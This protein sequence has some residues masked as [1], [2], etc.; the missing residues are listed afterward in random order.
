MQTSTRGDPC[1]PGGLSPQVLVARL[2]RV[3]HAGEYGAVR[4]YDGQLAVLG[5]VRRAAP[6]T[7]MI[8]EMAMAER[9]HLASFERLLNERRVR[10]TLLAPLWDGLGFALGAATALLGERAALACTA[11]IEEE[12]D[13]HYAGQI[14][15]LGADEAPLRALLQDYRADELAHRDTALAHGAAETPG[16]GLLNRA[17]RL[18]CRL[19]I[20]LSERI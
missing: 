1:R 10:P 3:D 15:H 7:T 20:R 12:I 11:A 13:R 8:R 18:G 9:R 2:L 14:A 17:I 6:T 5:A 16:Y 4:I 19:A